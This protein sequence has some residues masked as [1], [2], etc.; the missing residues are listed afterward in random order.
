MKNVARRGLFLIAIVPIFLACNSIA[1]TAASYGAGVF[2][3]SLVQAGQYLVK[4]SKSG[5]LPGFQKNDH[6]TAKIIHG[7]ESDDPV[8]PTF[9][10]P[11]SVEVAVVKD[12]EREFVYRYL[13]NKQ[14]FHEPWVVV[15]GWKTD[16]NGKLVEDD[17]KLPSADI[18]KKMGRDQ[19]M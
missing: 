17:L 11:I 3:D 2:A 5:N 1:P 18:Q 15:K 4:L 16:E 8:G 14:G 6:A 7:F 9:N 13:L 10:F 19:K 12:E